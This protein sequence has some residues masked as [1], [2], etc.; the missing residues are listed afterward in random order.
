MTPQFI[1][2]LSPIVTAGLSFEFRLDA[3]SDSD[4]PRFSY[5]RKR[6]D[7]EIHHEEHT[8]RS[9]SVRVRQRDGVGH[10]EFVQCK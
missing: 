5:P 9:Q 3:A 8:G 6:K 7:R 4:R 1:Q 2:I 10:R